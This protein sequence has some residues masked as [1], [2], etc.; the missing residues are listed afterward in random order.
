MIWNDEKCGQVGYAFEGLLYIMRGRPE[1][2]AGAFLKW[3]C[4]QL[5]GPEGR[6]TD[7]LAP[8]QCKASLKAFPVEAGGVARSTARASQAVVEALQCRG[9]SRWCRMQ[10][11]R[12]AGAQP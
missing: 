4:S 10:P 8:F 5:E 9:P 7:V 6:A 1:A 3:R 11:R 2:S 12:T